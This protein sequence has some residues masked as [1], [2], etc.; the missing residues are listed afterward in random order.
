MT[1]RR[2][3]VL[4][5]SLLVGCAGNTTGSVRP[6]QCDATQ[7]AGVAQRSDSDVHH[8]A[9]CQGSEARLFVEAEPGHALKTGQE[10]YTEVEARASLNLRQDAMLLQVAP[11]G[12]GAWDFTF[13]VS[14]GK[15]VP[16]N[17]TMIAG[18][19]SNSGSMTVQVD[20][21]RC[22][23]S[24]A[25]YRVHDLVARGSAVIR[26][27]LTFEYQCEGVNPVMRG[28]VHFQNVHE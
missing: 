18:H 9:P 16:G 6:A 21:R 23:P 26:A 8:L 14:A 25:T 3:P 15:L 17:Y 7:A 10:L 19:P 4:L 28:C 27:T 24:V 5:A 2:V 22:Q 12:R 20:G 1:R 11:A 13:S